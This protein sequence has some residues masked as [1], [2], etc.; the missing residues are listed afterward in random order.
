MKMISDEHARRVDMNEIAALADWVAA[1]DAGVAAEYGAQLKQFG[2]AAAFAIPGAET[3][4]FNRVIGLG[5]LQQTTPTIIHDLAD[6]YRDLGSSF[7]LHIPKGPHQLA[8]TELLSR[9]GFA[10]EGEWITLQ[11]GTQLVPPASCNLRLASAGRMQARSFTDTFCAGYGM[12]DEWAV[13]Y[14]PLIGRDRWHHYLAYDGTVPVATSSMFL[15]G[16]GAWFGN[17]TTL[18]AYRQRGL[19]TALSQLR[20]RDGIA[21]GCKFFTM[22][23]WQPSPGS[24]NQSLLNHVKESWHPVYTRVNYAMRY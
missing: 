5:T 23:T 1:L 10:Q 2:G 22:E 19:H 8:L 7:M 20:L 13:L 6:F 14:D 16:R 9:A 15:N 11:R 3:L 17:S 21:A 4:F 24:I 18:P 12:P